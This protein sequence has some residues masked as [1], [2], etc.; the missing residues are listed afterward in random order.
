MLTEKTE[1]NRK[2]YICEK[3]NF[4]S[5]DK[6]DYNKH[7]LTSKHK[8]NTFVDISFTN[9]GKKT[10]KTENIKILS[11][12]CGK[13]YKSR[14]GLYAHKKK[15]NYIENEENI[16]T[17]NYNLIEYED[18]KVIGELKEDNKELKNM[19][20]ELIKENAKQQQQI[21]ELIPKIGNTTNNT[22]NNKFNI[23]VFL[24]EKCKDALNMSDFIKSIEVSL[25][26]LD[27]TKQNGLANGLSKTI[28]DNMNKLSVYERPLHC[29]DVK[30]ETLYIK[31]ENEWSK[32][33][34]KEKI[35]KAIK[36]AS[37]KNYNAL[38]DWK[39]ENPDFLENDLKQEYFSKTISTIGKTDEVI[40]EKIIKN[41]CKETYIKD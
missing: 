19:I 4:I 31:E 25:Q 5:C 38:Q 18:N 2:K 28:M 41:L 26:Q 23:N 34:S 22:Q 6:K 7:I 12:N 13:Q 30:R 11:C 35:K 1:K 40:E 21:S 20:K 17:S 36:K 9:L 29:T 32:D 15:C 10:E 33:I 14:Q 3:C 24:N 8:N 16:L 37:S 39:T 27:F